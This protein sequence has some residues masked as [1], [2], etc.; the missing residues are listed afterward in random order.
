MRLEKARFGFVSFSGEGGKMFWYEVDGE[1]VQKGGNVV[2]LEVDVV[3]VWPGKEDEGA[4]PVLSRTLKF[5]VFDSVG[6]FV[7]P[8]FNPQSVNG[9]M[10]VKS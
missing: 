1:E 2:S 6:E 8:N 3:P 10:K 5:D 7:L 4:F 9:E